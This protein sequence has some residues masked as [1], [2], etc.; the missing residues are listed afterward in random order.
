MHRAIGAGEEA[1]SLNSFPRP[2]DYGLGDALPCALIE[3]DGLE[4]VYQ[5]NR[6]VHGR[7]LEVAA[8]SLELDLELCPEC[9][10]G[11]PPPRVCPRAVEEQAADGK[12]L[13]I[14]LIMVGE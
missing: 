12:R 4:E 8:V 11:L 3:M 1:V 2:L 9:V 14:L 7:A 6:M 10:S 13:E 5:R